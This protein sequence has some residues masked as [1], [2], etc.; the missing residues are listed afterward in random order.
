MFE[1]RL[2]YHIDWALVIAMFALCAL[3]VAMIYSSTADPTRGNSH[4][5]VTQLYAIVIGLGAMVFMLTLDYRT[6]TDK[7]HL[8]YIAVLGVLIYVIFFGKV[9]YNAR[10]W[11]D[12]GPADLQPPDELLRP[13]LR[14][15]RPGR[16]RR[17]GPG[18]PKLGHRPSGSPPGASQRACRDLRRGLP[19]C[20]LPHAHHGGQRRRQGK[21]RGAP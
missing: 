13:G 2:Y 21:H 16:H 18:E 9:Q 17:A 1:R 14:K 8:I 15:G 5:Y 4:L 6:F 3:G 20:R 7:S 12:M 10:R 11:I 19:V